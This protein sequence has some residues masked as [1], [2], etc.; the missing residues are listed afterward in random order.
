MAIFHKGTLALMYSLLTV[1]NSNPG[2]GGFE[3]H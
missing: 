3:K 1:I 2:G